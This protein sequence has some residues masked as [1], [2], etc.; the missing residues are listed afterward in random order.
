[1][2]NFLSI[3]QLYY[4]RHGYDKR[5][6]GF[7]VSPAGK[8]IKFHTPPPHAWGMDNGCFV[9]YVPETIVALLKKYQDVPNCKFAALPDS[10]NRDENGVIHGNHE[11]TLLLAQIWLGTYQ[12]YGYK[13]AFVLQNGVTLASVPFDSIDAVFVGGDNAL[14]Y[15]EECALII[16]E[17]K[18]RGKWVH[19]G[20]VNS[21]RRIKYFA[22]LGCDSFDGTGYSEFKV[23]IKRDY[24]FQEFKQGS[25]L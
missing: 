6:T 22:S 7:F 23:H 14:K 18:R 3:D 2:M 5:L 13:T 25:L 8:L 24:P 15:S 19:V 21:Q 9:K 20:R 17:A 10:L 1:M 16:K 4:D 11:E 12:R